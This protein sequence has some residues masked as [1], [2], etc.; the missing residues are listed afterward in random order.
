ML[1][2]EIVQQLETLRRRQ[3]ARRVAVGEAWVDTGFV[4]TRA[5]GTGLHPA[6]AS[7]W[8]KQLAR[9][10]GL[11]PIRLHDLCHGAAF[12]MLAAGVDIKVVADVLGPRCWPPTGQQRR[13][14]ERG[15]AQAATPPCRTTA[16]A[17]RQGRA[18]TLGKEHHTRT[19]KA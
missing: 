9:E 3:E 17:P 4:F 1:T 6:W 18:T 15:G 14:V 7:A 11:P 8:F 10:A 12:L 2:D 16:G 19:S 5:D 13:P